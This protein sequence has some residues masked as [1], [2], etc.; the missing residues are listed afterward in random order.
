MKRF[1]FVAALILLCGADVCSGMA[2]AGGSDAV[3]YQINIAHNGRGTLE[4]FK[5][6][7][8]SLWTRNLGAGAISYPLIADGMVFVTVANTGNYGTQLFALDA[9]TGTTVWQQPISGTYFWSNAAYDNGQVFVVNYN[10][11]VES[12]AAAT[13]TL[14]W[15]MQMPGQTSFSSPPTPQSGL[16]Y[17]AGAGEGGTLYAVNESNGSVQWTQSVENGD[18]SSPTLGENG[19]YVTYPC[20]YY[21]FAPAT[22]QIIWHDSGDCE[23][24]GG[25]TSVWYQSQL[26]VR[27]P[28]GEGESILNAKTGAKTGTFQSQPAPSFFALNKTTY[29]VGLASGSLNAFDA[30]SGTNLWS[31]TGDGNLTTAPLVIG[32]YVVEG[33][34]SGNLYVL[35]SK[36]GKTVW[37]GN[38]G[39]G[40]PGP[41]EQ[42]VSQPLTGLGA[43]NGILVVPAGSQISAYMP[44]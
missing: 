27:D 15:S 39:A 42:N 26:F 3:A 4:G 38:A 9:A 16:L 28:P 13:G 5:G 6:K 1:P 36:N 8:K 30:S 22:G 10:G 25:K 7:L 20:Q 29:G 24:G 12:F 23:G 37:S 32:K 18:N 44:Q 40:I 31:F 43:A 2:E 41:D 34:G 19:V 21:K 33:S 17:L 14:S 35:N 11:V